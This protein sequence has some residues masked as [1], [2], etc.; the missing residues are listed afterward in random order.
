M[1]GDSPFTMVP[2]RTRLRCAGS[3]KNLIRSPGRYDPAMS[4][5]LYAVSFAVTLSGA[6]EGKTRAKE[7]YPLAI[8]PADTI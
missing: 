2:G 8:L 4:F 3:A 1:G 5:L 6:S 7:E